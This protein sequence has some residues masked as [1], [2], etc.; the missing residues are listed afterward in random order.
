MRMRKVKVALLLPAAIL[1]CSVATARQSSPPSAEA[2]FRPVM[3]QIEQ[4]LPTLADRGAGL[5]ALARLYAQVGDSQ[6]AIALLKE[7]LAT[8]EG[9]DPSGSMMLAPLRSNPEFAALVE[10]AQK[11]NPAVHNARVAFT[12]PEKDLL[13]EGLAYDPAKRVFFMG[14]MYRRKIVRMTEKGEVSD[15]VKAGAYHLQPIG[16]VHVDPADQSVWAASDPDETHGSE[17]YHFDS[18]GKLLERYSPPGTGRHDLNDLVLYRSSAIYVTD[19]DAN[20]TYRFDRTTHEFTPLI[21]PRPQ[22][23]PNGITLSDDATQLYIADWLGVMMVDLHPNNK[24]GQLGTPDVDDNSAREVNP[25]EHNTLCGV[26][27]LYW[28]KNS[29]IGVQSTGTFRVMRWSLSTDGRQVR[30]SKILERGTPLVSFPTTGAIRGTD[31][32]FMA[33]TGIG[34]YTD[35]GKIADPAKLEPVHIAVVPLE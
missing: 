11:R 10:Q 5:F 8:D 34:N 31:F 1:L 20:L 33:N 30:A 3:E 13:P 6:K 29:L 18:Q 26:D 22:L 28:Y 12:L 4:A 2:R 35:D 15:F 9:I 7:S 24:A 23:F 19:T 27:G 16:G 32:Y 25:G 17:L 21:L 14:S